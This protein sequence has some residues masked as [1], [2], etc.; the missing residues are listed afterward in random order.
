MLVLREYANYH[1]LIGQDE[2]SNAV[3]VFRKQPHAVQRFSRLR[4]HVSHIDNL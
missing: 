3:F 4:G 2:F 1:L